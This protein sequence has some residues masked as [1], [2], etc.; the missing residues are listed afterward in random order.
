VVD[1]S[2]GLPIWTAKPPEGRAPGMAR[3]TKLQEQFWTRVARPQGEGQDAPSQSAPRARLELH[4]MF[5]EMAEWSK[6]LPC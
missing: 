1:K 4:K 5:G 2:A 6:A 3:V